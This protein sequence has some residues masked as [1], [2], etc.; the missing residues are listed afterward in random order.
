M[1]ISVIIPSLNEEKYL[2]RTLQHILKLP[3]NF[4]III[5]DGGSA[6][7]TLKIAKNFQEVKLVN[8]KKGR[9]VQMNTGAEKASGDIFLFLHADTFLPENAYELI[10]K[11]M[12]VPENI[13]GSFY[14]TWDKK[15]PILS[16]YSKW[17]KINL[18]L[19]TYGDHAIFINKEAFYKLG[20]YMDITFMEDIE[21]QERLRKAGKFVKLN[22]PVIT[23]ARRFEKT[24]TIKQF[25]I[26][27]ILVFSYKF[28]ASP[29]RLKK[30]YKDHC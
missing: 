27:I 18:T 25:L 2:E 13:A 15:H 19:F 5:A 4:E 16:M 30:F 8:S 23:S 12:E 22:A 7:N 1:K 14:L 10:T 21:I 3:G 29:S 28:G 6:D 17:S 11:T 9:A 24:G 20:G 26:D